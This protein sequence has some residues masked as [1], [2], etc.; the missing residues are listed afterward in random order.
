MC[1]GSQLP[2]PPPPFFEILWKTGDEMNPSVPFGWPGAS[3]YPTPLPSSRVF[4][5]K[6]GT[7]WTLAEES[8]GLETEVEMTK[9][10]GGDGLGRGGDEVLRR[11]HD[12]LLLLF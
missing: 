12:S 8:V 6:P 1:D 7:K 2:P 11:A 3:Q 5:G 4:C 9:I 10:L